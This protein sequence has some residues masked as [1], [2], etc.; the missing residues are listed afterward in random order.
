MP[1]LCMSI[2]QRLTKNMTKSSPI[3]KKSQNRSKF[4]EI[5]CKLHIALIWFF[6][7]GHLWCDKQCTKQHVNHSR[8]LNSAKSII[9]SHR[10]FSVICRWASRLT[11]RENSWRGSRKQEGSFRKMNFHKIWKSVGESKCM[12]GSLRLQARSS[13]NCLGLPHNITNDR[14]IFRFDCFRWF[15]GILVPLMKKH[16]WWGPMYRANFTKSKSMAL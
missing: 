9:Y 10:C 7:G 1:Q 11:C 12:K 16:I 8:E 6:R 4:L 2:W 14:R 15:H 5:L 13:A 3:G